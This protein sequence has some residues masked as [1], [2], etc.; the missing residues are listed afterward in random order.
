M[1]ILL[2]ATHTHTL[3]YTQRRRGRW[4]EE[5]RGK[6]KEGGR[7][8][9]TDFTPDVHISRNL[10]KTFGQLSP[11]LL[12]KALSGFRK[13]THSWSF[14]QLGALLKASSGTHHLKSFSLSEKAKPILYLPPEHLL[15][16]SSA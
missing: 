6:E 9:E 15:S 2:C 10:Q 7:E 11:S 16:W 3:T 13:L 14:D 4:R 12:G 5:E 1:Y 8:R